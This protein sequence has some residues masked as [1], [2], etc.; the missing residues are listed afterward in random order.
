MPQKTINTKLKIKVIETEAVGEIMP[1]FWLQNK[2]TALE[3]VSS[4][5]H[6]VPHI[7]LDNGVTFLHPLHSRIWNVSLFRKGWSEC[8]SR[9]HCDLASHPRK[10]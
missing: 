4:F 2:G 6:L 7:R 10:P 5:I 8:D 9:K 3:K 1:A